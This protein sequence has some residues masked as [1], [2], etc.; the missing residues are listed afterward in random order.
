MARD[1]RDGIEADLRRLLARARLAPS[2]AEFKNLIAT[3]R[4]SRTAAAKLRVGLSR[5]DEPAFGLPPR[6]QG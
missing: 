6:R 1:E 2:D 5:N 3:V 4:D